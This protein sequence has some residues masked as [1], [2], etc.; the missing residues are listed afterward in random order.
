MPRFLRGHVKAGTMTTPALATDVAPAAG[1]LAH[2]AIADAA[3]FSDH[4]GAIDP[5]RSGVS[6]LVL[7]D[8]GSEASPTSSLDGW[9]WLASPGKSWA[10]A[11]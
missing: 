4:P 11:A 5:M 8:D 3:R 7:V 9:S 6:A 2:R 1:S 10:K